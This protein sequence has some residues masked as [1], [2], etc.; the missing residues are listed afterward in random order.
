[1]RTEMEIIHEDGINFQHRVLFISVL[2]HIT[3]CQSAGVTA[4]LEIAWIE[5]IFT[6]LVKNLSGAGPLR[7]DHS[8]VCGVSAGYIFVFVVLFA[9]LNDSVAD[10]VLNGAQ[11]LL[12]SCRN[13][14]AQSNAIG[15]LAR[16]AAC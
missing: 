15:F 13:T 5:S 9:A 14:N 3:D 16:L 11:E 6:Y 8:L 4:V 10:N 1:M 12:F 7:K 2:N